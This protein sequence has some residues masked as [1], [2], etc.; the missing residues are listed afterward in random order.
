VLQIWDKL[1]ALSELNP[2][3]SLNFG[4]FLATLL[5]TQV[6]CGFGT[7]HAVTVQSWLHYMYTYTWYLALSGHSF[8]PYAPGELALRCMFL[9]IDRGAHCLQAV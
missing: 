6:R 8:C 7:A 3:Q 4:R 2:R 1:K 9:H 5:S